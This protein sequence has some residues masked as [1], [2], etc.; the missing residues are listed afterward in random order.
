MPPPRSYLEVL[1]DPLK[2]G[3]PTSCYTDQNTPFK[4][5]RAKTFYKTDFFILLRQSDNQLPLSEMQN[6]GGHQLRFRNKARGKLP[7]F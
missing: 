1:R 6:N 2:N 4:D 7:Q 5:V 3:G